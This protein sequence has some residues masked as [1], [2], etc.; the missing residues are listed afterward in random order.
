MLKNK[1]RIFHLTGH[2][3]INITWLNNNVGWIYYCELITK[4]NM[5]YEMTS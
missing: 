3:N 5:L 2:I 4:I 1:K